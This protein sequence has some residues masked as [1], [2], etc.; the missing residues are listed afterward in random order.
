MDGRDFV[1]IENASPEITADLYER[2]S[3]RL[4]AGTR[5]PSAPAA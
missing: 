1:L 2:K 3:A 5:T 4:A